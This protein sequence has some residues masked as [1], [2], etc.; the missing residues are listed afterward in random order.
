MSDSMKVRL[1]RP[2]RVYRRGDVL[3]M[4]K[5]QAKSWIVAG[6]AVEERQQQLV[7]TAMAEPEVRTADATPRRKRR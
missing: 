6:I 5:G 1:I 3:D 4:P 2:F 7:E